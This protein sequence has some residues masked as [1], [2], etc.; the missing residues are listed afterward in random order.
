MNATKV[1][2][3]ITSII[4]KFHK[5]L[6]PR[7]I[8]RQYPPAKHQIAT[9]TELGIIELMPSN[10]GHGDAKAVIEAAQQSDSAIMNAFGEGEEIAGSALNQQMNE[11]KREL[12]RKEKSLV[13]M[14][15][16]ELE[17]LRSDYTRA[18]KKYGNTYFVTSDI[19]QGIEITLEKIEEIYSGRYKTNPKWGRHL[20]E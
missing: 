12:T 2:E 13:A 14:H 16:H 10:F 18:K 1:Q 6:H 5:T 8:S 17:I 19:Y 9:L 15:L 20:S 11:E 4:E 7:Q 3:E